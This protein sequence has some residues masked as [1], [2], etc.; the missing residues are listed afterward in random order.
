MTNIKTRNRYKIAA[1]FSS[2]ALTLASLGASTLAWF[3]IS[4]VLHVT[5]LGYYFVAEENTE[6]GLKAPVELLSSLKSAYYL[7]EDGEWVDNDDDGEVETFFFAR[8]VNKEDL[9][10]FGQYDESTRLIPVTSA[11]QSEW[12]GK[13]GFERPQFAKMPTYEN[14]TAC[15]FLTD[16]EIKDYMFQF[17]FYVRAKSASAGLFVFPYSD[18]KVMANKDKNI[19]VANEFNSKYSDPNDRHR[20]SVDDVNKVEDYIRVSFY[21]EM[22]YE[23]LMG[24]DKIEGMKDF[25]TGPKYQIIDA[26]PNI[27]GSE[28]QKYDVPYFGRLD[29]SPNDGYY[30]YYQSSKKEILYGSYG[31][32]TVMYSESAR[33]TNYSNSTL[34][35]CFLANTRPGIEPVLGTGDDHTGEIQYTVTKENNNKD[36]FENSYPRGYLLTDFAN[37]KVSNPYLNEYGWYHMPNDAICYVTHD[38][39][40]KMI[41]SVWAE[42]WDRDCNNLSQEANFD[43][44]ISIGSRYKDNFV[45]TES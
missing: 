17:T 4:N 21:S 10:A 27:V 45:K 14:P 8:Q 44:L 34:Q 37:Q 20:I 36:Y 12:F 23:P 43:V 11:F 29:I 16:D 7:A 35:N 31:Q 39:P 18:T 42:G 40:Q 19:T 28:A 32:N 2:V 22:T 25:T 24:D 26:S 6:F 5:D 1:A 41:V 9:L 15:E 38:K 30:D 33:E 3:A 13:P